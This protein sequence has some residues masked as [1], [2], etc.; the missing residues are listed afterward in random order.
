MS[1]ILITG[2]FLRPFGAD[3][4]RRIK[5]IHVKTLSQLSAK[6]ITISASYNGAN[7]DS[8]KFTIDGYD[9][10]IKKGD[11]IK[12]EIGKV[13]YEFYVRLFKV[14]MQSNSIFTIVSCGTQY[15]KF[16]NYIRE[17]KSFSKKGDYKISKVLLELA[18]LVKF[19]K[20]EI[21]SR[22]KEVVL[23]HSINIPGNVVISEYIQKITKEDGFKNFYFFV[24]AE[25][26]I[27]FEPKRELKKGMRADFTLKVDELDHPSFIQSMN[28][29]E[30]DVRKVVGAVVK[31]AKN[32]Q[33]DSPDL[34]PKVDIGISL[35]GG[36]TIE[37]SKDLTDNES[38]SSDSIG[39]PKSAVV[40][41]TDPKKYVVEETSKT[42]TIVLG[43]PFAPIKQ[44][45][46]LELQG[47]VFDGLWR[48]ESFTYEQTHN[49]SKTILNLES[50]RKQ[51]IKG[52]PGNS[53]GTDKLQEDMKNEKT[54]L[55]VDTGSVT[56]PG[57]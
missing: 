56:I 7:D 46:T 25:N 51:K 18:S 36:T 34:Q 35:L 27:Y 47:T 52:L 8:L 21:S 23:K 42:L 6:S 2:G 30:S 22:T 31:P 48:I 16:L 28:Y 32:K 9:P 55:N 41:V 15:Y 40:K 14:I 19:N 17:G 12:V 57:T 45:R 24:D 44:N 4:T 13:V 26:I 43:F 50:S 54:I 33:G 3:Q 39:Q 53:K 49:T 37:G 38:T 29:S 5:V 1:S 11:L 10:L 20:P